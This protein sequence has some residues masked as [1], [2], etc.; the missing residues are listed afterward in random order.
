MFQETSDV[1]MFVLPAFLN[2][3]RTFTNCL[4]GVAVSLE[5]AC[6]CFATVGISNIDVT[7]IGRSLCMSQ[8]ENI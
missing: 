4:C 3:L 1:L 8:P 5:I 7:F 2:A 6:N